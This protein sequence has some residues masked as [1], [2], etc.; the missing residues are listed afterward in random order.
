MTPMQEPTQN[1]RAP[2]HDDG[3]TQLLR[4]GGSM[5]AAGIVSGALLEI[6][7]G[8]MTPTGATTNAGWIALIVTLMCLPFGGLLLALGIAKWLRN[9]ALARRG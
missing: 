2:V 6:V 9:R 7:F 4:W 8:G 3:T 5:V 1:R